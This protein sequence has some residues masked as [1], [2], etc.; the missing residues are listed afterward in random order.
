MGLYRLTTKDKRHVNGIQIEKGMT[1]EV[2]F[3][4][5]PFGT[6]EGQEVINAAFLSKYN[7]DAAKAVI[8]SRT[9]LLVEK[10]S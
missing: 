8:I 10:I 2:V 3:H 5:D 1:V 7:V 9:Y 6:R 4:T